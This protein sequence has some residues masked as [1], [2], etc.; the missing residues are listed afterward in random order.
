MFHS[1]SYTSNKTDKAIANAAFDVYHTK[2]EMDFKYVIS[3]VFRELSK[4]ISSS[5]VDELMFTTSSMHYSLKNSAYKSNHRI[6]KY[7]LYCLY[8]PDQRD[9]VLDRAG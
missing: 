9:T 4:F 8:M 3:D 7:I 1:C 2:S 5:T 6:V